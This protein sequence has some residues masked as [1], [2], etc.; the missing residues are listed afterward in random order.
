MLMKADTGSPNAHSPRP[1]V[2]SSA[3]TLTHTASSWPPGILLG[4]R[5]NQGYKFIGIARL[6]DL[7]HDGR[8]GLTLLV[9]SGSLTRTDLTDL[10]FN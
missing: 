5:E 10:I 7:F 6:A 4:Y 9:C 3:T 2:P 8:R 1:H